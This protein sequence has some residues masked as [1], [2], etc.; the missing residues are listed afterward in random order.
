MKFVGRFMTF[1]SYG[2]S[3]GPATISGV[4]KAL[5]VPV[6]GRPVYLFQ[7]DGLRLVRATYSASDG[8]FSFPKVATD[9]TWLLLSIDPTGA[10]NAVIADRV[11]T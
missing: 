9:T 5:T 6:S 11:T 1:P 7:Q 8:S 2:A 10:Y 3:S 4:T